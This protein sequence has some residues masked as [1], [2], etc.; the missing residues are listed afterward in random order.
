M[1]S[2][3]PR[4]TSSKRKTPPSLSG[5]DC[6]GAFSEV[7]TRQAR[8]KQKK[9]N[10][11]RPEFQFNI[12]ELKYGK[13]VTL[14]HIRD[15]ILYIVADGQK[16]QWI[17]VNNK[18]HISHTVLLFVP[19]L[20]PTHLGLSSDITSASMPF[21]INSIPA[22]GDILGRLEGPAQKV[23]AIASLFTYGCPTRAPGDKLRMHSAI[24]QLLMCP[25]QEHIRRK[26]EAEREK[27]HHR[28][29]QIDS[30]S[31][32]LYLLTPN[33]MI[34]NDY[35]IPS[36][37]P[38]VD[39]RIVPGLDK[40]MIPDKSNL[41]LS[42][43]SEVENIKLR[44]ES[45]SFTGMDSTRNTKGNTREGGWVETSPAQGPPKDG[46]YPILAIDC[47]M[48]VS[49]DGDE[50]ARISVIDF[51]S[52]KNVFDE[53]VLPP[54]EIVDYR[55]QWSGITAER[56]LSATHT[57]SS[58][59]NLL[60]SG[61]SPLITP[62]TILLGH[63]L[64]CDLNALRIRHPL[65]IDTALIYKHPRGPPFKPGLKWLSQKWL[66][67]D[68]Q[69]GEN[70]HDSEED[71]R[72]CVDLLKMK[73]ANGPDFGDS[74]NNMEPIVERIGRYMDNSPESRKTSAYCDYGD[75][76]WL[77]G[78]K[79]TTAVRCTSDD[80]VVNAVVKNVQSHTFV[81]GRMMEL[82]EAQG[83]ND[84]G[85]SL[86]PSSTVSLDSVLER[87]NSR[88]TALH[89]SLPPNTALIIVTG[90]S[91]PLPMVK[92]TKKRQRWERSVKTAGIEGL[93]GDDRWMAEHDRDLE[94][95]VEEAKAGMAFFRV[96]S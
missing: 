18:S 61:A 72:A 22:D 70:G 31:P 25:I 58:I 24:N 45:R 21:A 67:R 69:A 33:Q 60:L 26:R 35:N 36:Y 92:L 87:F 29:A 6:E 71:A 80:D 93:S 81:F 53:L 14:A 74:T 52:G 50:L 30:Y 3:S 54:G 68:I 66:Q 75:P 47:E 23:P 85:A 88:L 32:L 65:C 12:Q 63:S 4:S 76:R 64:E 16:P 19:G 89:S 17:Q 44:D 78:A 77:Y 51:N 79:A 49:K 56:L 73:L 5:S 43:L 96:T 83:W 10:K 40:S 59:Q 57:I 90:H 28:N 9:V 8:R 37:L 41:F 62:H 34:D 82:S 84:G 11:H 95:A 27:D 20:L 2:A 15:L 94:K 38:H 86:S 55:T 42:S 48:V 1:S 7:L 46:I 13:K 39:G 91:D